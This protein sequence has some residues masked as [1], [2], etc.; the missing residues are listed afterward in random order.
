MVGNPA[1]IGYLPGMVLK[2][3]KSGRSVEVT[4]GIVATIKTRE[5]YET[6]R[7]RLM[8][9]FGEVINRNRDGIALIA[10]REMPE[11]ACLMVHEKIWN[12]DE[13]LRWM[14]EEGER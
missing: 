12:C 3:L 5:D 14:V 7:N 8:G 4:G 6:R 2:E 9:K 10:T 13:M 1:N 11:W